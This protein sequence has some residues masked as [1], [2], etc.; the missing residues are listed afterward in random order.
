MSGPHPASAIDT[1]AAARA[2]AL[3]LTG[4]GPHWDTTMTEMHP[5]MGGSGDECSWYV[6]DA[7]IDMG[8][9]EEEP[10]KGSPEE[11]A[12]L[13]KWCDQRAPVCK[14]KMERI[15]IEDGHV[16]AHRI[17]DARP[18]DL[19]PA[20]G[21]FWSHDF[22]NWPDPSTPWGEKRGTFPTIVIEAKV[23]VEVIDW[24]TSCTALMDWMVGDCEAELRLRPGHPLRD[25]K[26]FLLETMEPIELP[27][28]NWTS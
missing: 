2:F 21:I 14:A 12:V 22:D 15:V 3:S 25:V 16:T 11:V 13:T 17:I 19:R 23:P 5:E 9:C 26:A 20:L 8:L 6:I 7:C 4:K 28:R 10:Q 27:D 18:D 1:E 24:Q